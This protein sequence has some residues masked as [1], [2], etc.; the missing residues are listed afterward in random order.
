MLGLKRGTVQLS[1]H[2]EEW[3]QVFEREKTT[4]L[5]AIG[6]HVLEIEHVGSTAICGI[7]A[8]PILD[9]MVGIAKYE[10]GEKCVTGLK[11]LD[12][13][14]KGQNGVPE[15]HYFGKGVPRTHHLH[16][17]AVGSDFWIHHLLFRDYLT[18][19]RQV[20]EEYN[21]L[22]LDLAARFPDDREVYTNG[23]ESFVQKVLQSAK[24]SQNNDKQ[25]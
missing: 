2:R 18:A 24:M 21:D 7:V 13:E 4:I 11:T 6:E 10:E 23:K 9:I 1:P 3:H 8:K 14:Y 16:M 20:A 22:K 12:Y 19:N 5:D 25:S 17:V 15:R